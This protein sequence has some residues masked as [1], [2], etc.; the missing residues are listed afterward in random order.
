[1]TFDVELSVFMVICRL[2]TNI[3]NPSELG[4]HFRINFAA[5]SLRKSAFLELRNSLCLVRNQ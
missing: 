4:K 3:L 1:M 5:E 2:I